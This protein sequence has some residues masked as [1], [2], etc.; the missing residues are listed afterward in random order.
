MIKSDKN[1]IIND[2]YKEQISKQ[3]N[4]MPLVNDINFLKR[5]REKAWM[6]DYYAIQERILELNE[7][8]GAVRRIDISKFLSSREH[9]PRLAYPVK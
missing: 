1:S 2:R 5:R 4:Q 6:F 9:S 3:M 7:V 8:K